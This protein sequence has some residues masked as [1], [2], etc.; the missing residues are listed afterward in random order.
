MKRHSAPAPLA[1]LAALIGGAGGTGLRLLVDTVLPHGDGEFPLGTLLLNVVGAF[2]L[3]LI[4]ARLWS[5]APEWLRAGLGAGLLGSFTTFSAVMVSVV[6]QTTSGLWW[7][8]ALYLVLSLGFGL[9][10]AAI[11]LRVGRVSTP[12]D[13]VDE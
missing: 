5:R 3:G 1:L 12:I 13:W 2:L 4:V 7:M 11:G 10:A 9:T 8:A 6:A